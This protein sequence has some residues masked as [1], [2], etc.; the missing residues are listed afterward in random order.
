MLNFSYSLV[1]WMSQHH[2]IVPA[3]LVIASLNLLIQVLLDWVFGGKG[4]PKLRG[5]RGND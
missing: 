5:Y 3:A 2:G 1:V 4:M